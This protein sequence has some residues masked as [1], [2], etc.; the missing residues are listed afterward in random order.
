MGNYKVLQLEDLIRN[1]PLDN[2]YYRV[3]LREYDT[4]VVRDITNEGEEF[5]ERTLK[6]GNMLVF[7]MTEGY[8]KWL[9]VV[10]DEYTLQEYVRG[11]VVDNMLDVKY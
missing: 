8:C 6:R 9:S 1:Y 2:G 3:Q 10:P 4:N 5:L 7:A 11:E